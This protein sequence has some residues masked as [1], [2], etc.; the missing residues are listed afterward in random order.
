MQ[1]FKEKVV[2]G[3]A[4]AASTR[5]VVQT[6]SWISTIWVA[7]ILTPDD[8]GI[9][10]IS[11]VFTGLGLKF[12]GL[13]LGS[14]LVNRKIVKPDHISNIFWVG[15]ACAV[16]IYSIL[17]VVAANVADHYEIS[18]L[19]SVI[20][21]AALIVVISSLGIVPRALAMRRL[22][23]KEAAVVAM[24]SGAVLIGLTLAM[25]LL[26][27]GY[28]SLIIS[29]VTAEA[30][31]VVAFWYLVRYL[32]TGPRKVATVVPYLRYGLKIAFSGLLN[33][34]N[35]RWAIILVSNFLGQTAVGFLQMARILAG[36]PMEKVGLIFSKIAFPAFSRIQSDRER[37]R[38]VFLRMHAVLY[39][40]TLPMFVGLAVVAHD[41]VPILIGDRWAPI[42]VP[43]QIICLINVFAIG[44]RMIERVLGGLA[45][46][47]IT[48][49]Y[50]AILL[51]LVPTSMLIGAR[52]GLNGMLLAWAIT[53]PI[54]YIY[55]A[56]RFAVV[57]ACPIRALLRPLVPAFASAMLMSVVVLL[58]K[59]VEVIP[60][61][62]KI[63]SLAVQIA[64][65]AFTYIGAIILLD[66]DR[67]KEVLALVRR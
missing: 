36:L 9:V 66:R 10:A 30:V 37:R 21:V 46:P 53:F 6:L 40:A 44:S 38:S 3:F 18:S 28:W 13:G 5:L 47:D 25:A 19:K 29:T 55:L 64:A 54:G 50:Q 59:H 58:I 8:Y 52:W 15:V 11:G 35:S 43:V 2:S 24:L 27:F 34:V 67:I 61:E 31:I 16:L 1:D 60:S 33:F 51:I 22:L 62:L 39:L 17:Y 32:P 56:S 57:I 12:A 23:L 65:G 45:R 14:A 48:V 4:W 20:R 41:L 26:G 49:R 42:V 7:R 63:L